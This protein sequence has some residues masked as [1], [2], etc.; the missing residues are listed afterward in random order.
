M[1]RSRWFGPAFALFA[2]GVG[3]NQYAPLMSVYRDLHGVTDTSVT[4]IFGVYVL[5]LIPT[6]LFAGRWSD[7]R[8]RRAIVLPVLFLSAAATGVM[9]L[10][11][12]HP[13]WLY[14]GRFLTGLASGAAFGAGSAW[15]QEASAFD[16]PGAGARRAAIALSGGFGGGALVTGLLGGFAPHPAVVPYLFHLAVTVA[17]LP[18]TWRAIDTYTPA[19]ATTRGPLVPASA[20]RREFVLGVGVWA[21]FVFGS[22]T[23]AFTV[24]PR[25]ALEGGGNPVALAGLAAG[26]TLLAGILVQP[27]ARRLAEASGTARVP[28]SGLLATAAGYGL[29]AVTALAATRFGGLPTIVAL[30]LVALGALVLGAAYGTLLVGGL[31]AVDEQA[32]PTDRAGLLAVFYALTYTGFA[33]P[34]VVTGLEGFGGVTPWF[35]LLAAVALVLVWVVRREERMAAPHA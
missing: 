19:E 2:I 4:A 17:A 32:G 26:L 15:V 18:L 1:S 13:D 11:A 30:A 29:V 34:Y 9:M 7:R 24:S 16:R 5:G 22:A 27:A 8:G 21:P 28:S 14:L 23:I 33:V 35:L 10:G 31:A 12:L 6:L 20:W 3:A 25:V